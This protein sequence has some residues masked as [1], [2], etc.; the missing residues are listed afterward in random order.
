MDLLMFE[1]LTKEGRARV[2]TG[3]WTGAAARL[4]EADALWRGDPLA[5]IPSR[6]THDRYIHYLEQT[7]LTAIELRIEAE[8]RTSRHHTAG[9]IPELQELTARHPERE[10]LC[11]LLILA[12]YR[13]GRQAEALPVF[14]EARHFT[15]TEYGVDPGPELAHIQERVLAHD[16]DLLSERLDRLSFA[17]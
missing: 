11:L 1:A 7:R 15:I 16:R 9:V 13:A 10:R 8:I 5:D 12:L 6:L 17:G 3:D 4:A 14:S 2:D